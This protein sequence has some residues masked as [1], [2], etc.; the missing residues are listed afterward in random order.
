MIMFNFTQNRGFHYFN[1]LERVYSSISHYNS[2]FKRTKVGKLYKHNGKFNNNM[3]I[4]SLSRD[5]S[6]T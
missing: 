6:R 5:I 4:F 3:K 1:Y 2:P